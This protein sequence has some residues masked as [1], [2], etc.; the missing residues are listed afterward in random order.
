MSKY[1]EDPR[2]KDE[3][4]MQ[5]M[6]QVKSLKLQLFRKRRKVEDHRKRVPDAK[7]STLVNYNP[8]Q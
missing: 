2:T 8:R 7:K 6:L 4:E 3:Q 5:N 1:N